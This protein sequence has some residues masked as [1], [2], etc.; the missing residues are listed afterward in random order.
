M[1]THAILVDGPHAGQRIKAPLKTATYKDRGSGTEYR[2][3]FI[4]MFRHHLRVGWTAPGREP[5]ALDCARW[6]T[7]DVVKQQLD[8]LWRGSDVGQLT[9][10]ARVAAAEY[11]ANA[12]IPPLEQPVDH[13]SLT[14][15]VRRAEKYMQARRRAAQHAFSVRQEGA[16][17]EAFVMDDGPQDGQ[18]FTRLRE[19]DLLN[20][21][22]T[23]RSV[24]ATK[25]AAS[26]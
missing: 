4:V 16:V 6:L 20:L 23:A 24:L 21:I 7:S 3:G 14:E 8:D 9:R 15:V 19:D 17:A 22:R 18:G 2:L 12:A 13:D 11:E 25:E 26:Q 10:G 5:D 1:Q